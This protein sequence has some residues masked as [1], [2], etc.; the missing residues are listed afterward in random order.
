[1][2]ATTGK[3]QRYIRPEEAKQIINEAP[4]QFKLVF[5]LDFH[6]GMRFGELAGLFVEY[7]DFENSIVHIPRSA[8]KKQLVAPKTNA[9]YR[10]VPIGRETMAKLKEFVGDRQNGLLFSSRNGTPLVHSNVNRYVLKPI[11]KKL[12]IELWS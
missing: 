8:Y 9:G 12:G 1:M 6:S 10:D 3:E 5:D 4:G 7:L 11:C 2:P